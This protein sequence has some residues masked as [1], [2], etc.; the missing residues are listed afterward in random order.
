VRS[1]ERVG[2]DIDGVL[3]ALSNIPF[4][5]DYDPTAGLGETFAAV[6]DALDPL[7]AQLD[8]TARSLT[9]FTDSAGELQ[10]ELDQLTASVN[11][12]SADLADS[13]TLVGQYRTSVDDARLLAATT[14]SDLADNIRFMRVLIVIAGIT[15]AVGQIV[16]LWNGRSLLDEASTSADVIADDPV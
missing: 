1:L 15:F 5:P 10:A 4:G 3:D 8:T 9:D 13:D 16:P 11:M 12:V 7:P 6:A 2:E 14:R